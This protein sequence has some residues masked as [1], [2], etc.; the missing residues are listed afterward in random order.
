MN[1]QHVVPIGN[2]V[3]NRGAANEA[4]AAEYDDTHGPIMTAPR[5][6]TTALSVNRGG[7]L[8]VCASY[9]D[10][11]TGP[12]DAFVRTFPVSQLLAGAM[13]QP[14]PPAPPPI[15]K[16]SLAGTGQAAWNREV[17]GYRWAVC[18][19][20]TIAVNAPRGLHA[21][22]ISDT[23]GFADLK[24]TY[25]IV[26]PQSREA[27]IM[28]CWPFSTT[29][30]YAG[31]PGDFSSLYDSDQ[32]TRGR[33]VSTQ[34]PLDH[35]PFDDKRLWTLRMPLQVS[36]FL[37]A[38]G[39]AVDPCTSLDLDG[40]ANL[41]DG[42][43]LLISVGHDE[44]WSARM[45]DRL[46][47]FVAGGG[48]AAFFSANTAWWQIRVEDNGHTVAS[49]KSAIEDAVGATANWASSPT[50]RE[51]NTL[52]GV[53]FRRGTMGAST[54]PFTIVGDPAVEPLLEGLTKGASIPTDGRTFFG[55][56]TDAADYQ[57]D[58][59]VY[60]ATGKDGT[61]LNF[62]LLAVASMPDLALRG[63]ATMGYFTNVGTV[64]TGANTDWANHLDDPSVAAVTRNVARVLSQR[65]AGPTWTLPSRTYPSSSWSVVDGAPAAQ[66][67]ALVS[68]FQGPLLIHQTDGSTLS[69]DCENPTTTDWTTYPL[70][71]VP[72]VMA[73]GTNLYSSILYAA[74]TTGLRYAAFG[75]GW[76]DIPG[77]PGTCTA[78]AAPSRE[79]VFVL[80]DEAGDQGLYMLPSTP[81]SWT[82]IGSVLPRLRSMTGW[83]TKLLGI[84]DDGRLYC[85]ESSPVD[86]VWSN[87]GAGPP[88]GV[89]VA[90][91]AYFGRLFALVQQQQ[92]VLMWRGVVSEVPDALLPRMVFCRNN[93]SNLAFAVG[94]LP[95]SGG[96]STSRSGQ[97]TGVNATHMAPA[98][99][100]R[101]F[102][103]NS[104]SR[105]GWLIDSSG[106]VLKPWSAGAFGTW[107]SIVNVP[108]G[109]V[110]FYDSGSGRGI[111][112]YFD[113]GGNFVQEWATTQFSHS[114]SHVV[115]TWA[116]DLFF[117]NKDSGA[118]RC[119]AIATNGSFIDRGLINGL[120][121]G[122]EHIV[123]T[124][125]RGLWFYRASDGFGALA[126]LQPP[127]FGTLPSQTFAPGWLPGA[128]ANGLVLL[129]N[130]TTGQ[131]YTGGFNAGGFQALR[132]FPTH[133][134]AL[135]WQLVGPVS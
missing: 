29:V 28:L 116:G 31:R 77:A 55:M 131:G 72:G 107:T 7:T 15:T 78:V 4:C 11:S 42:Y 32:P 110:L 80:A 25:Y 40:E 68:L 5:L 81:T 85:R 47:A 123:A 22:Q 50:N 84:S 134:F 94:T 97:L 8:A 128:C 43:N 75:T 60:S 118:G 73:L 92:R 61:P 24:T 10:G 124:G 125:N 76:T 59:G 113:G 21:V 99:G 122:W 26:R 95:G 108:V 133:A 70:D 67:D 63:Q 51:E 33:R 65:V 91:T 13:D 105:A 132:A 98:G 104:G 101:V 34:R 83:D 109:R 46:E 54:T 121:S 71:D 39:Y 103:Y 20:L 129:Q 74:G 89:S 57:V 90:M 52:T 2:E 135:G 96:F 35:F 53:S 69:G 112:G 64:F 100:G 117:Y 79:P 49:Y 9:D 48:N 14:A 36:N 3:L 93:G 120:I 38:E 130:P 127:V 102:L 66:G 17:V 86:L 30:A 41:L 58:D 37:Q 19:T 6:Y 88:G 82:R 111:V 12:R 45:R 16:V 62:K 44:Y 106:N 115:T 27:D 87:V 119:G 114:W 1:D 126:E 56:E 23:A 18:T